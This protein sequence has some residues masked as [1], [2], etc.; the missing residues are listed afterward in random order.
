MT[1]FQEI[2][3]PYLIGPFLW[4]AGIAGMG[5]VAYVMLAR[6]R[7]EGYQRLAYALLPAIVLALVFVVADLS[8]PWNMPGAILSSI[9]GGT[10]GWVRSWM[11]VGIALISLGTVLLL[12]LTLRYIAASSVL[13]RIVDSTWYG[14]LLVVVGVLITIYSGFL[15]AAA[16]G[17]PF[18]NTALIPVLW[19]LSA[20]VCALALVELLLHHGDVT[21][22]V[23]R[24]GVA[25]ESAELIAV[26]ALINLAL[27]GGS[28][29]ARLSA[30]ALAYGSLAA[31][32]WG[33]L[34]GLGVVIPLAIGIVSM[35][36]QSRALTAAA[37]VL[38][39]IGALLL[40]ILVLQAGVF[41]PI[42]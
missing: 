8:R 9:L 41:E 15:I 1:A 22:Q 37:A 11:A 42:P 28:T 29:A 31:A 6:Q 32:F 30:Q 33:G 12:F 34:V 18:W 23:V 36:R 38:A 5:S 2:W 25:L 16:P 35:K 3:S 27:Y 14:V 13:V 26:M 20:S 40:R 10:F 7:V 4:L 21:R 19:L 24:M 17:I 39:L